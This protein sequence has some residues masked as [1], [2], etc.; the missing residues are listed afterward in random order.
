M[1][2]IDDALTAHR[3]EIGPAANVVT[4]SVAAV[5]ADTTAG[6][7]DSDGGLDVIN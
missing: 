7:S 6:L 5:S 2:V 1:A 4:G 3:K